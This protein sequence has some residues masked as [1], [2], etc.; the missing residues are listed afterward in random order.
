M[1]NINAYY[2]IVLLKMKN[3]IYVMNVKKYFMKNV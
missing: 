3:L 1:K 2:V